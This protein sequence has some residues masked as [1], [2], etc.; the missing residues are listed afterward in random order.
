MVIDLITIFIFYN[1]KYNFMEE[2]L[3]VSKVREGSE[4]IIILP[5]NN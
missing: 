2:V 5:I 1:K 4:F 3:V